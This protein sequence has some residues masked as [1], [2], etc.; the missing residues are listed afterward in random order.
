MK[1]FVI[2][3]MVTV[4]TAAAAVVFT[5]CGAGGKDIGKE[6]ALEA[7]LNDAGVSESDTT[8]LRVSSERDDGRK[9]YEVRF[10]VE[11]TEYD[12]EISG[13]D[14]Q[15][16]SVDTERISGGNEGADAA[17]NSGAEQG[18]G[19]NVDQQNGNGQNS[20][21]ADAGTQN[22]ADTTGISIEEATEIALERVPG[23]TAD[24]IRIKSD[25]DD[26]KNK[27]EGDIIFEGKEYEFEIVASTGTV[28]E[29]SEERY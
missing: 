12:Y 21:S 28:L 24:D 14:G 19:Q 22:G 17:V 29:W 23:A 25:Y 8:R 15:I 13:T 16:L 18:N 3:T 27:Y 26:G 9:V 2:M 1:K 10:D 20:G 11:G 5:G 7:A 6:A 4:M